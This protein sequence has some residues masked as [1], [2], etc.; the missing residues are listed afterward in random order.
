MTQIDFYIIGSNEPARRL[1]FVMKLLLKALAGGH[2]TFVYCAGEG[3]AEAL[4]EK[5]W[6]LDNRFLPNAFIKG[7]EGGS[8]N[9]PII[10]GYESP[11][12]QLHDLYINLAPEL[13]P[14]FSRFERLMEVIDQQASVLASGRKNYKS[15]QDKHYPLRRHDLRSQASQTA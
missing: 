5:L 14:E 10:I 9:Q 12:V 13:P 1:Q 3:E 11:P 15:Y 2:E 7:E 6:S 4:S 8:E